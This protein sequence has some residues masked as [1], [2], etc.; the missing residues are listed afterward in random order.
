MKLL[1]AIFNIILWG[2]IP[3]ILVTIATEKYGIGMGI[4]V[5][6]LVLVVMFLRFKPFIYTVLG[7][8]KY[9]K[10]HD[11]GFK[12]LQKAYDTGKM[13]P[14]Q[15]LIYAYLLIRDGHI[16]KAERLINSILLNKKDMLTKQNL[17]AADLN[18]A[19]IM[20][21][22]GDLK[23]AVEKMEYVY[24][25]GYRST[26]HYGTLGI[27]YILNNQLDRAEEFCN[28]AIEYNPSDASIRDNLG[29]LYFRKGDIDKAEEIYQKLF[30]DTNPEFIE[31]YYNY[32]MVLEKKGDLAAAAGYYRTALGCPEK[33]LSTVKLG[34]ADAALS[35]VEQKL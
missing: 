7:K 32:G 23:G 15:A 35:R 18:L 16:A 29:L 5:M 21:K 1:N 9:F 11:E 20:W 10:D 27:F 8:R 4:S 22:K 28:E 12:L 24:S 30:E 2:G 19:I 33:F 17:L 25:T 3:Y 6:I 14:Q 26:V 13:I 31:A 34:Q